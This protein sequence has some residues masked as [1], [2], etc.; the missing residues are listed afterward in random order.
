MN[1]ADLWKTLSERRTRV[2]TSLAFPL[3]QAVEIQAEAGYFQVHVSEMYLSFERKLWQQLAPA[4]LCICDF[5]YGPQATEVRVPFFVSNKM[6]QGISEGGTEPDK[7]SI[8]LRDTRVLG[9][10]PYRGGEVGLFAGL[11]RT[12][13]ADERKALFSVFDKLLGA[14]Q[15]TA[16][17][18][19]VQMA[20]KISDELSAMF[21][22]REVQCVVAAREV[23]R[24]D[25]QP[26]KGTYLALLDCEERDVKELPLQV[27][28]GRLRIGA[29]AGGAAFDRCDYCLLRLDTSDMR[30]DV[31][32]L[33][34]HQ[35]WKLARSHLLAGES[36]PARAALLA[37]QRLIVESDD[38]TEDHRSKLLEFYQAAFLKEQKRIDAADAGPG[39]SEGHRGARSFS[40]AMASLA[41]MSTNKPRL[42]ASLNRIGA[43]VAADSLPAADSELDQAAWASAIAQHLRSAPAAAQ[44]APAAALADTLATVMVAPATQ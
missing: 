4:T 33:S 23:F 6:F 27:D 37:C 1:L 29:A 2:P 5:K 11:Y 39:M 41:N 28:N 31:T 19:Y 44:A 16:I 38:L 42:S 17:L 26:L 18:P 34:F 9:P 7:V 22:M 30:D 21:G 36:G 12:V 40:S 15:V 14:A 25:M 43:L 13:I 20:E 24:R 3:P 35:Q 32:S 10:V 8:Q